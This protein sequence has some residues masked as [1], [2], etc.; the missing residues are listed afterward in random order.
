MK[1]I[2][3]DEIDSTND[4]AKKYLDDLM[5]GFVIDASFQTMGRGR[6]D[7]IWVSEKNQNILAS[8][9]LKPS[10]DQ[11]I[12]HQLT[13]VIAK[14]IVEVLFSYEVKAQIKWPN[15]I[16]VQHKKIAGVLI[17]TIFDKDK[18]KGVVVG[19]GLNVFQHAG[20]NNAICLDECVKVNDD[21]DVILYKLYQSIFKNYHQWLNGEYTQILEYCNQHAY[22]KDKSI[23][24]DNKILKV[25][26]LNQEGYIQVINEDLTEQYILINQF[27]LHAEK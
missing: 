5:E 3:F 27:S 20:V 16:Y 7:H 2:H 15:D 4:Y 12:L 19:I 22:L 13:Q 18:R 14:A 10:V 26:K 24:Y 9:V 8:F 17:E 6:L 1:R 21:L 25:G 11:S 23:E